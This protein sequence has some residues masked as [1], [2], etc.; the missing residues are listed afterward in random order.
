MAASRLRDLPKNGSNG[1]P[2]DLLPDSVAASVVAK[3]PSH[4]LSIVNDFKFADC[5][6]MTGYTEVTPVQGITSCLPTNREQ[7]FYSKQPVR[8]VGDWKFSAIVM[9]LCQFPSAKK[10]SA[11]HAKLRGF[12]PTGQDCV[13]GAPV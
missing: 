3:S 8:K 13:A 2:N 7:P 12:P 6:R 11:R 9:E 5:G 4:S 1:N 10:L